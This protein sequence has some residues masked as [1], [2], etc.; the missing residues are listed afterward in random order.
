MVARSACAIA[1]Y[2]PARIGG[3]PWQQASRVSK[4]LEHLSDEEILE[5]NIP[6]GIPMVYQLDEHFIVL[7]RRFLADDVKLKA[8]V[9]EVRNQ[10]SAKQD[11][12]NG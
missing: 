7:S 11:N 4:L 9:D 6:T 8:A 12:H 1:A 5:F 10:A 2:R 3:R